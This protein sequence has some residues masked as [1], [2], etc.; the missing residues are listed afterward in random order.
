[1]TNRF[2]R[3]CL[4]EALRFANKRKTF[5]KTLIQHPVIRWKIAEMARL[6]EATHAWLE[7]ITYQMN[8]MGKMEA[9]LKLGGHTALLKVQCTKVFEYCAREAAQVFGG[10]GYTRGG[11]GEKVERLNREVR[12]MAVP[13]GSEEIMLDLGV[14]QASKL[15]QMAKML[16]QNMSE[17]SGDTGAKGK[18]KL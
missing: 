3:V 18:A 10:L 5:G 9:S 2:S 6:T 15:A 13:G 17:A 8:T 11:Q 4:E 7:Q 1:M 14:R 16:S 12:A